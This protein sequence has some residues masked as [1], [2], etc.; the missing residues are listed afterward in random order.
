[1]IARSCLFL[2][3]IGDFLPG[4]L[5]GLGAGVGGCAYVLVTLC[6]AMGASELR[7]H[8]CL[9]PVT[10]WIP[11]PGTV[12]DD[13]WA[14]AKRNTERFMDEN[15]QYL[16]CLEEEIAAQTMFVEEGI[17]GA[18]D[19]LA[20]AQHEKTQTILLARSLLDRLRFGVTPISARGTTPD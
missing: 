11:Q 3:A 10:P 7:A 19:L 17:E 9:P 13:E 4:K 16:I 15:V 2:V 5:R 12:P 1:M 20:T 6:T 18:A 14:L 8:D